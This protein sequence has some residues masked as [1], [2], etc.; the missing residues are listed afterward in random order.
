MGCSET[1]PFYEVYG[2][3]GNKEGT[4][5]RIGWFD[6]YLC[7]SLYTFLLQSS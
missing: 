1:S 6:A 3:E 5:L 7:I 4:P 2:V